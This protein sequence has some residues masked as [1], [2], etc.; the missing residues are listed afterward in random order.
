MSHNLVRLTAVFVLAAVLC[1]GSAWL[2]AGVFQ[3]GSDATQTGAIALAAFLVFAVVVGAFML[4]R[5]R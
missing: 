5:R 3:L 4:L 2:A 1:F